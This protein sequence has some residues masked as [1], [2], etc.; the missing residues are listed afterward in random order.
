MHVTM[1][2]TINVNVELILKLH[3]ELPLGAREFLAP[4]FK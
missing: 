3:N 4:N 1:H 2:I